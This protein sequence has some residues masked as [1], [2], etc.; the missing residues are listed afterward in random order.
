MKMVMRTIRLADPEGLSM[1]GGAREVG[2]RKK[3][4]KAVAAVV[5]E[6]TEW[7][8]LHLSERAAVGG[9]SRC[10]GSK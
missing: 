7:R 10:S 3:A 6:D 2:T 9:T 8:L 4:A 1:I 5:E